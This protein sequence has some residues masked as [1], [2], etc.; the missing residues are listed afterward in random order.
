MG[1]LVR[2]QNP[3]NKI[4]SD[5]DVNKGL[6]PPDRYFV[7]KVKDSKNGVIVRDP[8][9]FYFVLRLDQNGDDPIWTRCCRIAAT[10]LVRA[11]D[12]YQHLPKLADDLEAKVEELE[13]PDIG[14]VKDLKD[15]LNHFHPRY[16]KTAQALD[17]AN[18]L[19]DWIDNKCESHFPQAHVVIAK[20]M[21]T[22]CVGEVAVW[23]SEAHSE[24]DFTLE[25]CKKEY[26]DFIGSIRE[27]ITGQEAEDEG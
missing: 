24:E 11:L 27:I 7:G 16:E 19:Q 25:F 6:G 20:D 18:Q 5:I 10:A 15:S 17:I 1:I 4:P 3:R 21:L 23:D 9:A 2:K 12:W 22:I 13:K 8:K 26:V 14:T